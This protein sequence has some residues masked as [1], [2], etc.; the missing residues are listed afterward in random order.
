MALKNPMLVEA[1]TMGRFPGL[2]QQ[3]LG[4]VPTARHPVTP[5][6]LLWADVF[7][8]CVLVMEMVMGRR[9]VT[10]PGYMIEP[11][12]VQEEE[13]Q[14]T[15][16]EEECEEMEGDDDEE[17][18]EGLEEEEEEEAEGFEEEEEEEEWGSEEGVTDEAGQQQ[19]SKG[20]EVKGM[21]T[22]WN[23]RELRELSMLADAWGAVST[24]MI[25]QHM[26]P[27]LQQ[28]PDMAQASSCAGHL[29][30]LV[31]AGLRSGG[32]AVTLQQLREACAALAQAVPV[33]PPAEAWG[34]GEPDEAWALA[35]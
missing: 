6:Q 35:H 18:E 29:A 21:A 20:E 3:I 27:L 8:S 33:P 15:S 31:V 14:E 25:L 2:P 7:S 28:A 11:L 32:S 16:E 22:L 34:D 5:L 13:M 30:E 19:Q 4:L 26:E 23:E 17:E 12:P 10:L 1:I 9:A 24:D